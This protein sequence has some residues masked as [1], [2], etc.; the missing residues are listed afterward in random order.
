MKKSAMTVFLTLAACAVHAGWEDWQSGLFSAYFPK[1]TGDSGYSVGDPLDSTKGADGGTWDDVPSSVETSAQEDAIGMYMRCSSDVDGISFTP[2]DTGSR[3]LK[4]VTTRVRLSPYESDEK[5]AVPEGAR[6]AFAVYAAGSGVVF[7]GLETTAMSAGWVELYLDSVQPS[8]DG[9]WYDVSMKFM[10]N[11]DG[12]RVQY[13][14]KTA[15]GEYEPLHDAKGDTWFSAVGDPS[16]EVA[17]KIEYRGNGGVRYLGGGEPKRGLLIGLV[18]W[19]EILVDENVD[20][21]GTGTWAAF[22]QDTGAWQDN[23]YIIRSLNAYLIDVADGADGYAFVPNDKQS[24][25]LKTVEFAVNF[26][27]SNDNATIPEDVSALVR[28]VE[29]PL[30]DLT[31]TSPVYRFACLS[32]GGWYTNTAIRAEPDADYTVSI[33]QDDKN[34]TV[35]YRIRRGHGGEGGAYQDLLK[36]APMPVYSPFYAFFGGHGLVYEIKSTS[37]KS[38]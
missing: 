15:L 24:G 2:F 28:I 29:E 4:T 13:R 23:P 16:R 8:T 9:V 38:E 17:S 37:T 3:L 30:T 21:H 36:S 6:A 25:A 1:G 31:Q 7:I 14:L 10:K 20:S 22:D 5:P 12:V 32:N 11:A 18:P 35:T 33:S 19:R 26:Y 27:E 34:G